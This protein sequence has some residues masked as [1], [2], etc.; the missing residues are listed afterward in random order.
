MGGDRER[1]EQARVG[2]AGASLRSGG[3]RSAGRRPVAEPV[4]SPAGG[5]FTPETASVAGRRGAAE[6]ERRF[7][8]RYRL[9]RDLERVQMRQVRSA[10]A[11]LT[12]FLGPPS[13]PRKRLSWIQAELARVLVLEAGLVLVKVFEEGQERPREKAAM[14]HMNFFYPLPPLLEPLKRSRGYRIRRLGWMAEGE[15]VT[16]WL[17]ALERGES[18]LG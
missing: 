6:R 2:R 14:A 18:I 10:T 8:S 12:R 3:T 17:R 13:R 1:P 9:P 16:G 11:V 15:E 7:L 4:S 5:R